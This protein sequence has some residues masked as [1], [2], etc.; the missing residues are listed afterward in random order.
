M[1]GVFLPFLGGV[2]DG[3]GG[4]AVGIRLWAQVPVTDHTGPVSPVPFQGDTWGMSEVA[5]VRLF[6]AAVVV[7]ALGAWLVRWRLDARR[8]GMTRLTVED[9]TPA[10]LSYLS[11]GPPL[12]VVTVL[13]QL[14]RA[15]VL[16]IENDDL[17]AVV[18]SAA[19]VNAALLES[20]AYA[21]AA[22]AT[23]ASLAEPL[24]ARHAMPID[25][26][27]SRAV[28]EL[29]AAE[30]VLRPHALV[31]RLRRDASMTAL[32]RSLE[33]QGYIR[34]TRVVHRMMIAVTVVFAPLFAVGCARFLIGLRQG[35]SLGNL[36][37]LLA[38]TLLL[39]GVE[40]VVTTRPLTVTQFV[41]RACRRQVRNE[42]AVIESLAA[43]S[44]TLDEG[45]ALAVLGVGILWHANPVGAATLQAPTAML[46]AGTRVS[47][48]RR[49]MVGG[50]YSTTIGSG[51]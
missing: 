17:A 38:A 21:R 36:L 34:S 10:E 13:W 41:V 27:V 23:W 2:G 39:F 43:P 37:V 15:G 46:I 7:T 32:E 8:R 6:A 9:L 51:L 19:A 12:V 4:A 25:D 1:G 29:V 40:V 16:H 49:L 48:D 3:V 18:G 14:W 30:G 5:F 31:R 44:P 45:R 42:A 20:P 50:A 22:R 24:G 11:S 47:M 33:D 28:L 35:E 26:D